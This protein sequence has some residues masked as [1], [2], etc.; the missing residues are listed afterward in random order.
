MTLA[1]TVGV[2]L[3]RVREAN[4]FAVLDLSRSIPSFCAMQ[5][6]FSKS[7]VALVAALFIT[8]AASAHPGHAPGDVVAQV[9]QPLA[10]PD[11]LAAFVVL[12]AALMGLLAVLLKHRSSAKQKTRE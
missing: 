3:S 5:K 6:Y 9:S 7:G 11:H 8:A 10:G 1:R 2:F 12:V 4:Q